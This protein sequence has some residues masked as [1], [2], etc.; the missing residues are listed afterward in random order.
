MH[1]LTILWTLVSYPLICYKNHMLELSFALTMFFVFTTTYALLISKR[2]YKQNGKTNNTGLCIC[3]VIVLWHNMTHLKHT[4]ADLLYAAQYAHHFVFISST[5]NSFKH[6]CFN[7][8][9]RLYTLIYHRF[10]PASSAHWI[11][12]IETFPASQIPTILA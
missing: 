10:V 11:I 3:A 9:A 2:I 4:S 8:I 5:M 12:L 7:V 6:T 1:V